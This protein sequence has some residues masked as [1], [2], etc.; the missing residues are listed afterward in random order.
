MIQQQQKPQT[1][2]ASLPSLKLGSLSARKDSNSVKIGH[3]R[4]RNNVQVYASHNV[5]P[6]APMMSWTRPLV[7]STRH[8]GQRKSI[9]FSTMAEQNKAA[10]PAKRSPAAPPAGSVK[11]LHR[12]HVSER[13]SV[14]PAMSPRAYVKARWDLPWLLN[15]DKEE[16]E[17]K[18]KKEQEGKRKMAAAF[19]RASKAR[20]NCLR[21]IDAKVQIQKIVNW[22]LSERFVG[23]QQQLNEINAS[24]RAQMESLFARSMPYYYS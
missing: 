22:N 8:N 5:L 3:H 13:R 16:E 15:D 21:P 23:M 20:V 17:E 24:E 1:D 10:E 11:P 12:A 4:Y 19:Q 9:Q 7:K 6:K 14:P 18:R 2:G